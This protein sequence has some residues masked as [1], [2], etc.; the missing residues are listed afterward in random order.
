MIPAHFFQ[1]LILYLLS[2]AKKIIINKFIV[3]PENLCY[4]FKNSQCFPAGF[5]LKSK[6]WLFWSDYISIGCEED[7]ETSTFLGYDVIYGRIVTSYI[8]NRSVGRGCS[9]NTQA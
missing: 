3:Q 4:Y 5:S 2:T 6:R 7:S 1:T 8:Q 9:C